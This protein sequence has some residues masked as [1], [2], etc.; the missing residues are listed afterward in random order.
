MTRPKPV[1][2]AGFGT[3]ADRDH[4]ARIGALGAVPASCGVRFRPGEALRDAIDP[5]RAS[6]FQGRPG[7]RAHRGDERRASDSAG[8]P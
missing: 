6:G 2:L 1:R 4:P 3:I 8:H 7:R 5:G